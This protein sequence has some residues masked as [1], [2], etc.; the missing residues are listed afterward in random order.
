MAELFPEVSCKGVAVHGFDGSGLLVGLIVF[1]SAGG[2]TKK[3]PVR[4][5]VTGAGK[6]LGIYKG[7]QPTDRMAVTHGSKYNLPRP[8]RILLPN[9]PHHIFQC[10]HNRQTVFVGDDDYN[11][12]RDNRLHFKKNLVA[13]FTPIV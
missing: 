8:L 10:G 12:Y 11:S 1:P 6:P 5:L 7:F 2:I 9:T 4:C 13:G 3:Y